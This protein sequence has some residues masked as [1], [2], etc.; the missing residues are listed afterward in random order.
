MYSNRTILHHAGH[1]AHTGRCCRSCRSRFRFVSNQGFR[2]EDESCDGSCI[3]KSRTGYFGRI[4]DTG[5]NH[6]DIFFFKGIE[7]YAVFRFFNLSDDDRAFEAGVFSDLTERSFNSA[8]DEV[9]TGLNVAFFFE[10]VEGREDVDERR[11]AARYDTFFNSCASSVEGIFETIFLIFQFDFRSSAD[12]DDSDT[13]GHLSQTFLEFFFIEIR[14]RVSDLRFDLSYAFFDGLSIAV[15]FNDRRFIFRYADLASRAEVFHGNAVEFTADIFC[16]DRSTRKGCNILKHRF[17][18]VAEARSFNSNGFEGAAEAV[19]DQGS[20]SFAFDVFSDDEQFFA[21]LNDF[22]E[23]REHFLDRSD[24]AVRNEDIR[25]AH[26]SFHLIRIGYHVRGD[27]ASVELHAFDDGELRAHGLRFFNGDD[28]VIADFFHSVSDEAADFFVIC[29]DRSYLSDGSFVGNGDR[30]FFDFFDEFRRSF[31]NASFEDHRIGTGSDVAHAFF[32][33]SLSQDRSRRRA[34][35][36]YVVGLGSDFFDELSAHIFKG[37]FQFDIAGD[38]N[39]IVGDRRSPEFFIENDV[40]AFRPQGNFYGICQS[41]D[42]FA[43]STT[44]IFIEQNLFCHL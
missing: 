27:V 9:D 15:A 25:F 35:T 13:A 42:A 8:F 34:V 36:G 28:A 10:F 37:I 1:A 31:F 20:E 32:D 39:T 17:A 21:G 43:E 23:N 24:L 7:A 19:D 5:F 11:A 12:F 22:F 18:A 16:D 33:H 4:D 30:T 2:R 44:C 26:D 29:R 38:G 41:V 6:I 3:L 14:R 40:A